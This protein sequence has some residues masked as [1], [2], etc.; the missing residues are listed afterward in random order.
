[1][2]TVTYPSFTGE[3]KQLTGRLKKVWYIYVR[4]EQS[5]VSVLV[6]LLEE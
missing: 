2:K 6:E 1:M 4:V 5:F 3:A